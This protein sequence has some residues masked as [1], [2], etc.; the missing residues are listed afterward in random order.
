M[1]IALLY[2]I[3]GNLPALEAVLED[4]GAAGAERFVLGGDYALFGPWPRESVE[5]LRELDADWIRGNGERWTAHPSD[6]PQ[7]EVV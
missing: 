3:H 1:T 7:D 5:R 4:A 2:D 6:A